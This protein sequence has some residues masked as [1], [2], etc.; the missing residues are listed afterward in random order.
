MIGITLQT[1]SRGIAFVARRAYRRGLLVCI[2]LTVALLNA[3]FNLANAQAAAPLSPSVLFRNADVYRPQLS[4]DGAHLAVLSRRSDKRDRL[5]IAVINLDS[6]R[7]VFI[8]PFDDSDVVEMHWVNSTRLIFTTGNILESAGN[9]VPW[10]QGGMFAIDRDGN[11]ARRLVSP[12]GTG[13]AIVLRP[14]YSIFLQAIGEQSDDV[15]VAANDSNFD[16]LDVYRLNTRTAK[17]VVQTLD[18]PGN[19]QGWVLDKNGSPRGTV[20]QLRTRVA[21]YWRASD[22]AKWQKMFDGEVTE[23][24]SAVYGVDYDGSLIVS[25]YAARALPTA[26]GGVAPSSTTVGTT[27]RDTAALARADPQTGQLREWLFAHSRVDHGDL[28]FDPVKKKLVGVRFIDERVQTHWFDESWR[29]VQ[30]A[31]DLALPGQMNVFS[32]PQQ[33]KRML[34]VSVSAKNP[35][36]V[37]EFEFAT[38]KLKF[39]FDFRSG[40]EPETMADSRYFRF[41]ARDRMPLAA[42]ITLPQNAAPNRPLPTVVLVPGGPW[43]QAPCLCWNSEAQFFAQR[44]YAVIV[45][46][47]RGQLGLGHR[48]WVSSV[49]QW[50][51]AMQ[52]DVSDALDYAIKQGIADPARV[53]IMGSSYGGYA[54]LQGAAK[55]PSLYKAAIAIAAPTDLQFFHS[56]TWADYSDS[57]F[58]KYL[59]PILIGDETKDAEQL[60]ATSPLNNVSAITAQVLL[61]YGGED[62]RVPPQNGTRMR[63]AL[64]RANKPVE[65]IFKDDEGHGFAKLENRVEVYTKAEAMIRKAFGGR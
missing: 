30:R 35:G 9:T 60:R 23:Q 34:V 7:S 64:E 13:D 15:M 61:A 28:V 45:P 20:S 16:S 24:G 43:V 62:R 12:L 25:T 19:S 58:Q 42:I 2:A 38:R 1:R 40:L 21:S 6:N 14:R 32:P 39:L 56:I 46:T 53:A 11:N 4:P 50:G 48:H 51:L 47:F 63:N 54:A 8:T 5:N 27:L 44:G 41:P 57:Q 36:S 37:Y 59:A 52:D 22:S 65:W 49:K 3:S 10:R 26:P 55:T 29:S 18:S 17:K 31:I 33:S